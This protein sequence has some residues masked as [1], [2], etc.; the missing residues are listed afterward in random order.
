METI[1][2]HTGNSVSSAGIGN[3]EFKTLFDTWY[4]P[5]KNFIYY[6]CGNHTIAEEIAQETFLRVWEKR[7]GVKMETASAY[8]YKIANNLFI[9]N[10]Q[11][12]KVIFKFIHAYTR[13]HL[14]ESPEFEFEMKEFDEK[15]K[16]ALAALS[17]KNREVFLMNRIDNMTY[18]EIAQNL[19]LSVKAIEKRMKTAL[20][21][22]K[23]KIDHLKI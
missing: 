18:N 22:L 5:L 2:I 1:N 3:A 11:Q 4:E 23:S 7:D 13:N 20:D 19:G 15:L 9:N 16:R 14:I 12:K 8:M 17:E 6:K 21:F 10:Y